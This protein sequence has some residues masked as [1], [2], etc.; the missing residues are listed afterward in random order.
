[1]T[2]GVTTQHA[3]LAASPLAGHLGRTKGEIPVIQ[4]ATFRGAA[5]N[6][7]EPFDLEAALTY[8]DGDRALFQEL[9]N[10]FVEESEKQITDILMGIVSGDVI[11][12]KRTAHSIKGSA[13]AFAAKST[14]EAACHL[15]ILGREGKFAEL[16]HAA[17]VLE[18]QLKL[19][20]AALVKAAE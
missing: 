5:M 2:R 18:D 10:V 6:P 15:E 4:Q 14:A 16:P 19:L 7:E 3:I 9:V 12:V 1:M 8:M 13:S 17:L 11:L 20:K